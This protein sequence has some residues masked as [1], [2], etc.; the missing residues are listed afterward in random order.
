MIISSE[1]VN[2]LVVYEIMRLD[3]SRSQIVSLGEVIND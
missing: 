2:I 1:K 3:E